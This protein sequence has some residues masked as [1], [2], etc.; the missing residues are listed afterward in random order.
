M[1]TRDLTIFN[2]LI[3]RWSPEAA[4]K[5]AQSLNER[6]EA[7]RAF[8]L[9]ARAA[10]AGSPEAEFRVGRQYLEGSGVPRSRTEGMRWLERAASHGLVEAQ[11]LLATLFMH[12]FA[13]AQNSAVEP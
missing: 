9:Y 8:M 11:S 3:G 12:G 6:G 13:G 2:K 4:L 1:V 5:R 7:A 10:R